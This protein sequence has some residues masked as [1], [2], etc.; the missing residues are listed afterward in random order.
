[1]TRQLV[2]NNTEFETG[3]VRS[4][5]ANNESWYLIS[6]IGLRRLAKMY[7]NQ[8]TFQ[9]SPAHCL[10]ETIY[11][12]YEYLSGN[13]DQDYLAKSLY[14]LFLA[15]ALDSNPEYEPPLDNDS[16]YEKRYDLIPS[17]SLRKLAETY[18]EGEIKYG[19]YNVEKG[20]PIHD[21]LNHSIRHLYLYLDGDRSE[22]HLPHASWGYVMSMHSEEMWPEL[23]LKHLRGENLSLSPGILEALEQRRNATH[24][25]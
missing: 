15:I 12:T 10:N 17:I 3:A 25:Q 16:D 19:A 5:D 1:M 24:V 6:P 2:N 14:Y 7:A 23:N 4:G 9:D 18:K 22:P 13:R 20:M 11:W 21:L 8:L